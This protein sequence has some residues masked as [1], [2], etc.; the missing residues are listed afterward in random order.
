MCPPAK[1]YA[2]IHC[3]LNI[4]AAHIKD[5]NLLFSIKSRVEFISEKKKN[6]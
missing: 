1:M 2:K 6:L 4:Y 5:T 3:V